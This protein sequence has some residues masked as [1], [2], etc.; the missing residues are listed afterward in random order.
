MEKK[1]NVEGYPT[2]KA[3]GGVEYIDFT[4]ASYLDA[5]LTQDWCEQCNS[6]QTVTDVHHEEVIDGTGLRVQ[7][8]VTELACGHH[9]EIKF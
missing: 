3:V 7:Y 6:P 5:D 4:H 9:I 8:R 2:Q 1:I